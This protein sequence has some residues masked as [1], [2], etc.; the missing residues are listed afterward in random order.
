M[1]RVPGIYLRLYSMKKM[2]PLLYL[3][4]FCTEEG[5]NAKLWRFWRFLPDKFSLQTVLFS[6]NFK[7][8][9][10]LNSNNHHHHHHHN[11]KSNF[12]GY[13]ESYMYVVKSQ[14]FYCSSTFFPKT[15]SG[16][17]S[18]AYLSYKNSNSNKEN[19][20]TTNTNANTNNRNY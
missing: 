14:K 8:Q 11:N 20:T 9:T 13:L 12:I 16:K 1:R 7:L 18:I 3:V 6:C 4:L 15:F 19:T 17:I 5:H 2:E 10:L